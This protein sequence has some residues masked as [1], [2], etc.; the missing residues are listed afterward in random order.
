MQQCKH[1]GRL[2][3]EELV[4]CPS[5]SGRVVLKVYGCAIH[6]RAT[7]G[8]RVSDVEG[9]CRGCGQ[10]EVESMRASEVR[11]ACGVTTVPSR[12]DDGTLATTLRS[13]AAAGF[14]KPRLFVDGGSYSVD[15]WRQLGLEAT[16]R[17][18]PV[19]AWG[20]W[21]LGLTELLIREPM[22]HRYCMFQDDLL[23]CK[24]AKEYLSHLS[25]EKHT[26]WNLHSFPKNEHACEGRVGLSKAALLG[27]S[28]LALVFDRDTVVDLLGH[29][30]TAS[31]CMEVE[32]NRGQTN[33]DGGVY[34]TLCNYLKYREMVHWPCLTQHVGHNST[35]KGR[36]GRPHDAFPMS[37]S[38][39]G[40]EFDAMS[41]LEKSVSLAAPQT[42]AAT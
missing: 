2:M 23:M 11:W 14:D 34:W 42:Q 4:E 18:T 25:Y 40:E 38:F 31:R 6:G 41:L 5:C 28:G 15:W 20:N 7:L 29:T 32:H 30:N 37:E 13:L 39:R 17:H 27:V 35:L 22:C 21:L 12:I 36:N 9:C 1:L 16:I 24:G 10:M 8:K 19:S 26:Y 3:D 33:L